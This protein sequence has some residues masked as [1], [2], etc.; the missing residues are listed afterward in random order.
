MP[1]ADAQRAGTEAAAA[2][3]LM[4]SAGNAIARPFTDTTVLVTDAVTGIVAPAS[5]RPVLG[6]DQR[7]ASGLATWQ[8][9][10]S[11]LY[12][13]AD[14]TTGAHVFSNGIVGLRATTQVR[15][16]N[17]IVLY[18]GAIGSARTAAVRSI[19]Y[20]TGCSPVAVQQNGL[21]PVDVTVNLTTN[22]P[23]PLSFK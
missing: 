11:V 3:V 22:Y 9:G 23:P 12:T 6:D 15:T 4:D 16:P 17:G 2:V 1:A 10:G 20:D 5:I 7:P 21:A 19:R 18:V 8:S 14:C 13:S